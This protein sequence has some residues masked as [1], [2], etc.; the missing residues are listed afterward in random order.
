MVE[1]EDEVVVEPLMV[2]E[3]ETVTVTDPPAPPIGVHRGDD[4][5]AHTTGM[6]DAVGAMVPNCVPEQELPAVSGME[7]KLSSSLAPLPSIVRLELPLALVPPIKRLELPLL[8]FPPIVMV[9]LPLSPPTVRLELPLAPFPP[10][11]MLEFPLAPLPTVRLAFPLEVLPT[12]KFVL[13]LL[14]EPISTLVT[15]ELALVGVPLPKL[16]I[17][18]AFPTTFKFSWLLPFKSAPI[19]A[20]FPDPSFVLTLVAL[21]MLFPPIFRVVPMVLAVGSP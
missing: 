2:V 21:M 9:E 1:L 10:T 15:P 3:L 20:E 17:V 7:V 4:E 8:L 12:S 18:W 5:P 6:P 16:T 13:P 19:D 11:A 14:Y